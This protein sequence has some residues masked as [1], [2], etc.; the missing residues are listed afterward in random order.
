[1]RLFL[2]LAN[3]NRECIP[4]R[5]FADHKKAMEFAEWFRG[6]PPE[7][8]SFWGWDWSTH[9]NTIVVEF[10]NGRPCNCEGIDWRNAPE[11]FGDEFEPRR[12]EPKYIPDVRDIGAIAKSQIVEAFKPAVP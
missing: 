12:G 6:C 4:I 7:I 9:H 1:M 5:L 8:E 10:K 3:M 2:V 11:G